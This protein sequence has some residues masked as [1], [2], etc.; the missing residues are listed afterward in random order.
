M[1]YDTFVGAARWSGQ[2][3]VCHVGRGGSVSLC[4]FGDC[5]LLA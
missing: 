4:D 5:V 3:W 1:L 2:M